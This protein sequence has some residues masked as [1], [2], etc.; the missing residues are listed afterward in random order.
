M[1][2]VLSVFTLVIIVYLQRRLTT[3]GRSQHNHLP[4]DFDFDVYKSRELNLR[5]L[6]DKTKWR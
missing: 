1:S 6:F 3:T 5:G 4:Q 2:I